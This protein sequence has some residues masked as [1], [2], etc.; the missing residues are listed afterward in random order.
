MTGTGAV[1]MERKR[2]LTK[3]VSVGLLSLFFLVWSNT[4][5]AQQKRP[6]V[7][8]V[9][10][11]EKVIAEMLRLAD[12]DKDDVIYDLGCGD[13]RIVITAAKE[14]GCRGV[15]IDI[16]PQ[17][18]KDSRENAKKAGVT[19]RVEFILMDLFE[20]DI[21][22]STV[23][24]LYLLSSVN[25]RLRPKLFRELKPGTRV[26]SHDFGMA[27]WKPDESTIIEE[28]FDHYIPFDNS[29]LVENFWDKHNV[30][31]WI[32]PANVTGVWNWTL[33][34]LSGKRQYMMELN[35]TFQEVEG[36]ASEDSTLIPL[37]IKDGKVKGDRLE[38]TLER[39]LKGRLER[40]HF[41]GRV[42]DHIIEGT[43]RIEGKPNMKQRWRARRN[44]S[45]VKPIEQ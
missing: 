42:K 21:S 24:T 25:L 35:Q 8:Y 2:R 38:F 30:Y 17:R 44:P 22:K 9:P 7:P 39:K 27:E 41:E 45:T 40:L 10:T 18:I 5:G 32:I 37:H 34:A 1:Q 12:V 15:G 29:R 16:S 26:V 23:V 43:V 13:G 11:P 36:T 19:K 31:L 33:P 4:A 14:L 28:K 20:A 3:K 6:D